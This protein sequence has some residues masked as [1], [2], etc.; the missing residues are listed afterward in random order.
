MREIPQCHFAQFPV[1]VSELLGYKSGTRKTA[2]KQQIQAFLPSYICCHCLLYLP[3]R[4]TSERPCTRA[5]QRTLFE[6]RRHVPT[7]ASNKTGLVSDRST[8]FGGSF[9]VNVLRQQFSWFL[10]TNGIRVEARRSDFNHLAQPTVRLG[11]VPTRSAH[12]CRT[13]N[14]LR[15]SDMRVGAH[16]QRHS[17]STAF[18]E[19]SRNDHREVSRQVRDRDLP[20][21]CTFRPSKEEATAGGCT[22][23]K[24]S[25]D[26]NFLRKSKNDR[27]TPR[28]FLMDIANSG[29]EV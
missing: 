17:P 24:F 13:E 29:S 5:A 7:P 2:E 19:R 6:V 4:G 21:V 26:Q 1:T 10:K 25:S 8:V 18:V 3:C 28:A 11:K 12:S 23:T 15:H 9:L 27:K 20:G 22:R 16:G 14:R